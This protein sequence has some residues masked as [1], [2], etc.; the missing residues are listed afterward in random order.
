M[1]ARVDDEG[2][3][4]RKRW[5]DMIVDAQNVYIVR[6]S[7]EIVAKAKH[8]CLQLDPSGDMHLLDKSTAPRPAFTNTWFIALTRSLYQNVVDRVTGA[9]KERTSPEPEGDDDDSTTASEAPGSGTVT[10]KEGKPSGGKRK[11]ATKKR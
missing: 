11:R 2:E 5:V 6:C 8:F 9:S 7:I 3:S 4:V 10:P 1:A